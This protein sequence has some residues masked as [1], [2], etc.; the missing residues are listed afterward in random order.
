MPVHICRRLVSNALHK[1]SVFDHPN[2]KLISLISGQTKGSKQ[3]VVSQMSEERNVCES[4]NQLVD[5][6]NCVT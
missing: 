3:Q 4:E 1:P 6:N 2:R 5:C